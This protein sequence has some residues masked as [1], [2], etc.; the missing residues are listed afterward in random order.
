MEN[1]TVIVRKDGSEESPRGLVSCASVLASTIEAYHN[2]VK[3][4][5]QT[6]IDNHET[7]INGLVKEY[8]PHGSGI[9]GKVTV[10]LSKSHKDKIVIDFDFHCM[11]SN[12]FYAGWINYSVIVKPSFNGIDCKITGRNYHDNKEYLRDTFATCLESPCRAY[13]KDGLKFIRNYIKDY[14]TPNAK[15]IWGEIDSEVITGR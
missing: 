3:A 14:G 15:M 11:D 4:K 8:L 2:S 12:G 1:I 6:W 9:D 7:T 10:N 5:N 13:T